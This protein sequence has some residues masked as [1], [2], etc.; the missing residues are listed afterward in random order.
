MMSKMTNAKMKAIQSRVSEIDYYQALLVDG[1]YVSIDTN[2]GMYRHY[3]YGGR[4]AVSQN[5]GYHV[6]KEYQDDLQNKLTKLCETK[7]EHNK[8]MLKTLFN[9]D[10]AEENKDGQ[11]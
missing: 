8:H 7:I 3:P 2:Y 1:I 9:Y 4:I 6:I 11:E 5:L 10:Y